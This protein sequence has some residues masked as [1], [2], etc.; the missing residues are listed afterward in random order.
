MNKRLRKYLQI[1]LFPIFFI[2]A[3]LAAFVVWAEREMRVPGGFYDALFLEQSLSSA[4]KA[5]DL[6]LFSDYFAHR[7]GEILALAKRNSEALLL[8]E[9]VNHVLRE[10]DPERGVS[11]LKYAVA[12]YKK[13]L[14]IST[15]SFLR[16]YLSLLEYFNLLGKNVNLGRELLTD[17]DF[18]VQKLREIRTLPSLGENEAQYYE[19][20]LGQGDFSK[21]KAELMMKLAY[22]NYEADRDAARKWLKQARRAS[23]SGAVQYALNYLNKKTKSNKIGTDMFFSAGETEA[24]FL[25]SI[26][27]GFFQGVR[28]KME[29]APE[30][31]AGS[32]RLR[33]V[34]SWLNVP[35]QK[36]A[37][38]PDT[39]FSE[40][41]KVLHQ[42][43][44]APIEAAD[45]LALLAANRDW[46][47][48]SS[49]LRYQAWGMAFF[50]ARDFS[51]AVLFK[52]FLKTYDPLSLFSQLESMGGTFKFSV[53]EF[54]G[55]ELMRA[56]EQSGHL[57]ES[58]RNEVWDSFKS[59]KKR[60][61]KTIVYSGQ[62]YVVNY[63]SSGKAQKMQVIGMNQI[64]SEK[65]IEKATKEEKMGWMERF[66]YDAMA[67]F[68]PE[69]VSMFKA[70]VALLS[71]NFRDPI[72]TRFY[73]EFEFQDHIVARLAKQLGG[74]LK[75][76]QSK[77]DEHGIFV[78]GIVSLKM[79]DFPVSVLG[80]LTVSEESGQL[81]LELDHVKVNNLPLPEWVLRRLEK[82]FN[83]TSE[84]NAHSGTQGFEILEIKYQS[85]GILMTCR[86][87]IVRLYGNAAAVA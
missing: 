72:F 55:D 66:V 75:E 40:Y 49:F 85:G 60:V 53:K 11:D 42:H 48:Y 33:E 81:I 28:E 29:A 4:K 78:H 51:R 34:E 15:A 5:G 13:Q 62:V 64:T 1:W 3:L 21:V 54:V 27:M 39:F 45:H 35:V 56:S 83:L 18:R 58:Q 9:F 16:M 69:G 37:A 6:F 8:Y 59:R 14:L 61:S 7:T 25:K 10:S 82:G 79:L 67:Q 52:D 23:P 80:R 38:G 30:S 70:Q 12:V 46:S 76:V 17:S 24:Q 77:V 65:K 22:L 47:T 41:F 31:T 19:S 57:F 71:Q 2:F 73:S 26:R 87:N 32:L 50:D 86:N 36:N 20:L 63:D 43:G 68:V 74:S 44:R 84:I